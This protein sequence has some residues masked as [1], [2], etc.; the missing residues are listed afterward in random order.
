MK[1]KRKKMRR[2]IR[3]AMGD[4][5][6]WLEVVEGLQAKG[7]PLN[8]ILSEANAYGIEQSS[9]TASDFPRGRHVASQTGRPRTSA[10]ESTGS[11][12]GRG[13]VGDSLYEPNE[14]LSHTAPTT[15]P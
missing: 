9:P 10:P 5:R 11:P 1:G 14:K 2:A 6:P 7:I 8:L 4:R 12:T 13:G 3:E 15:T